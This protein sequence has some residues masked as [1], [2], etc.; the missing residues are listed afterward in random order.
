MKPSQTP[1]SI[2]VFCGASSGHE[3]HWLQQAHLIGELIA[4]QG[5]RLVYGAGGDGIMG[6]VANGVLEAGGSVLGVIPDFL[7]EMENMRSD[8]THIKIVDGMFERKDIMLK[9]SDAFLILPGGLG[10]LDEAFEVLTLKQ[11]GQLTQTCHDSQVVKPIVFWNAYDFW[12]PVFDLIESQICSGFV[13]PSN[14]DLF[15]VVDKMSDLVPS[16]SATT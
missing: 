15:T 2:C 7:V 8:L 9:E 5:W 13:A 14:R 6:T 16:L 1:Y 10:T 12:T 3:G 4:A 11:L